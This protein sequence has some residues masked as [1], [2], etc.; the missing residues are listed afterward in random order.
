MRVNA[1][2]LKN[3]DKPKKKNYTIL[4]EKGLKFGCARFIPSPKGR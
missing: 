1:K 3:F 2:L 4:R